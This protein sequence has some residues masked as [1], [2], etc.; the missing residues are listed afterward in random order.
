M[1]NAERVCA[2]NE[3]TDYGK[4]ISIGHTI[5]SKNGQ[6]ALCNLYANSVLSLSVLRKDNGHAMR[7]VGNI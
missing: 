5:F 7:R 2:E 3:E 4:T 6:A 1:R